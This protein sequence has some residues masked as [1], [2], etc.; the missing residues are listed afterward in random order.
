MEM[1]SQHYPLFH[2]KAIQSTIIEIVV[3]LGL[4][5]VVYV[6]SVNYDLLENIVLF[7]D[8]Y[9][10]YD[11]DEIIPVFI[12]LV[13]ALLICLVRRWRLLRI[14]KFELSKKNSLLAESLAEIKQLRGIIPICCYCHKIRDDKE[15][16]QAVESYISTHTEARFSHSICPECFEIQMDEINNPKIQDF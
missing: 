1:N 8:K 3:V 13:F 10:Y 12:F 7:T 2:D 4:S 16:W 15:M 11:L 5:I 9:E 14:A 6:F